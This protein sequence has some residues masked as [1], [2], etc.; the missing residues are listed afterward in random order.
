MNRLAKFAAVTLIVCVVAVTLASRSGSAVYLGHFLKGEDISSTSTPVAIVIEEPTA[1][2]TPRP[3][4]T[5]LPSPTATIQPTPVPTKTPSAVG[6]QG[7]IVVDAAVPYASYHD[8]SIEEARTRVALQEEMR[9][10]YSEIQNAD[11][12]AGLWLEHTPSFKVVVQFTGGADQMLNGYSISPEL[13]SII[14]V[15]VVPVS[16]EELKEAQAEVALL[17]KDFQAEIHHDINLAENRVEIY[18]ADPG[19]LTS[20]LEATDVVLPDNVQVIEREIIARETSDIHGGLRFDSTGFT[21][22]STS[23]FSVMNEDTGVIG[24]TTAGHSPNVKDYLNVDLPWVDEEDQGP[25][26]IQWHLP[27]I[28]TVRNWMHNGTN[29]WLVIDI[30]PYNDQMNGET[31]CKY[32]KTTEYACGEIDTKDY[33]GLYIRVTSSTDDLSEPGDS[34]GP[35]FFGNTAYGSMVGD[36]EPGNDAY[37]MAINFVDVLKLCILRSPANPSVPSLNGTLGSGQVQLSWSN[38]DD[39]CGHAIY[40]STSPYFTPSDLTLVGRKKRSVV[41]Y[42]SPVGVGD[43]NSNY[44]YVIR[45]VIG[46][47]EPESER[48]GEFDF[49]LVPGTP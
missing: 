49:V 33:L 45:P 15:R 9:A 46:F 30:R 36:I 38:P 2:V 31:V 20:Y 25:Y 37:Y 35:W 22:Y 5:L 42:N 11:T 14:E 10:I 28:Y 47:N 16:L 48:I 8:V 26:D 39:V 41:G 3:S 24:V 44:T 40:R 19:A 32:G 17:I 1:T 4:P 13:E 29:N 23:G 27:A 21:S 6:N 12:F 43:V 34:G 18:V 7:G